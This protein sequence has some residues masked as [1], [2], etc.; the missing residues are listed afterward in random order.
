MFATTFWLI[1]IMVGAGTST[2]PAIDH[3]KYD[4]KAACEAAQGQL[5]AGDYQYTTLH[6]FCTAAV[7]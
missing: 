1:I 2:V 4:N 3:I 7:K 5:A 6:S